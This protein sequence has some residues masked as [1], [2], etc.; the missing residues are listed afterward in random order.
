MAHS[1]QVRIVLKQASLRSRVVD[2][3]LSPSDQNGSSGFRF[4]L[5]SRLCFQNIYAMGARS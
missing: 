4:L 1:V 3:V 2:T 5:S